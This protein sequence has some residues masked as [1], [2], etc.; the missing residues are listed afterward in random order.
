M[1]YFH[2]RNSSN[3]VGQRSGTRGAGAGGIVR[4]WSVRDVTPAAPSGSHQGY[5]GRAS[6]HEAADPRA[7][8]VGAGGKRPRV[9]PGCGISVLDVRIAVRF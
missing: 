9:R 4:N 7:A 1:R 6:G 3:R 5:C 8:C 2:N